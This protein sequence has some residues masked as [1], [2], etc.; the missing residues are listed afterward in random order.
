MS[1]EFQIYA[2]VGGGGVIH[3]PSTIPRALGASKRSAV[4]DHFAAAAPA[5]RPS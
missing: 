4:A 2:L 1:A 3:I 5:S